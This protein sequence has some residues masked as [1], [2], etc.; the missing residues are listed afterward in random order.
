M[1]GVGQVGFGP[2]ERIDGPPPVRPLYGLLQAADVAA[3]GVRLVVDTE[4]GPGDLGVAPGILDPLAGTQRW[5]NGAEVYPYPPDLADVH[6]PCAQ[7]TYSIA[8]GFGAALKHPLFGAMTVHLDETCTTSRILTQEEFR[9][10]AVAALSA[11]ESAGVA[12]ELMFGTKMPLTPH[13]SDGNG[14]FPNGDT[15]TSV[16][17]GIAFLDDEIAKSGRLGLI[18]ISPGVAVIARDRWAISEQGGLLRTVNGN[19]VIPD[20]GYRGSAQPATGG[21]PAPTGTRE[22]IYATGPI[23]IRRS[24]IFVLPE[25]VSEAVDRGSGATNG[26]T[27]SITYRAERYYLADWDTHVQAAVLV[28]RCFTTCTS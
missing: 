9:A 17:H 3:A 12:H 10:R 2:L 6:D 4:P 21:H 25:N 11:V 1:G 22:W 27:N 23:D 8:K 7:G 15:A 28:D 14:T 5:L 19:V 20:A 26:T 24:E 18:H 16:M 13:F